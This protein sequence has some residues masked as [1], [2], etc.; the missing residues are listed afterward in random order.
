MGKLFLLFFLLF[1]SQEVLT[2]ESKMEKRIFPEKD[3]QAP[4]L[5]PSGAFLY[6][7]KTSGEE[8]TNTGTLKFFFYWNG[9]G[10][11][12]RFFN[13]FSFIPFVHFIK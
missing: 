3:T 12:S 7:G 11:Y 6:F 5:F 2:K 8:T 1:S 9:G 13:P 4:I 10:P